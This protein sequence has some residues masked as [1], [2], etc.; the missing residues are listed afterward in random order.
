MKKLL[1]LFTLFVFV[2]LS[3]GGCVIAQNETTWPEITRETKPW[4]RWWWLGSD[5]DS[6]NLSYNLEALSKAG[7]GGVEITPIFGVKG[8]EEYYIDYLSPRWMTMLAFTVSEANRLGMSVDM[9]NGT[10]WPFGGPEISLEDAATKAIFKDGR[11]EIGKTGQKVK[12]AAP[13]RRNILKMN[14]L[15]SAAFVTP[16]YRKRLF[17]TT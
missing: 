11:L 8:R 15:R 7:I 16:S 9:N 12:R 1:I 10:G 13:V 3:L 5:V 2:I 4:T 17:A 14:I 6:L